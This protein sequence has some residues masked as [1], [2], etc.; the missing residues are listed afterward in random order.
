MGSGLKGKIV[1][2]GETAATSATSRLSMVV[3]PINTPSNGYAPYASDFVNAPVSGSGAFSESGLSPADYT[4]QFMAPGHVSQ[5]QRVTLKPGETYDVGRI[6]LER[7]RP[8]E[9]SYRVASS[10]PFGQARLDRQTVL[11]G[12]QFRANPQDYRVDLQFPQINGEIHFQALYLPCS[13]ADLGP[14]KL[15]DF[16]EVDPT[17]AQFSDLRSVVPHPGHVYLLDQKS[18][19][20]W[21]LFELEFDEQKLE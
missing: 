8:I 7:S 1:L 13:I 2:D 18:L 11:G 17:V 15:D 3:G 21:V 6:A 14:G 16:L 4:L 5:S 20:H 19:K 9:V 12:G 10:P